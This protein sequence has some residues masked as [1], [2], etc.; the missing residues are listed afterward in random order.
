MKHLL[1]ESIFICL[2]KCLLFQEVAIEKAIRRSI[3][4]ASYDN[5][6]R[7]SNLVYINLQLQLKQIT[8]VNEISQKITTSSYLFA[9][10]TDPRLMW[11]P[12]DYN[13]AT[14]ITIQANKLWLPDL[15]VLNTADSNGFISVPDSNNAYVFANGL[16]C[17]NIGLISLNTRCT[18]DIT[19]VKLIVYHFLGNIYILD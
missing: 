11:N 8:E 6:E 10:W 14:Y 4:N 2:L 15:C 1:Q 18:M 16:V 7:P 17:L 3:L 5:T 19:K 9:V 12:G 13:N